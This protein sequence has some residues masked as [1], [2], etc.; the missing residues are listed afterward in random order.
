[1]KNAFLGRLIAFVFLKF[2]I[3]CSVIVIWKTDE[4]TPVLCRATIPLVILSA[5]V[6]RMQPLWFC[7]SLLLYFLYNLYLGHRKRRRKGND[8]SYFA[9]LNPFKSNPESYIVRFTSK[10]TKETVS[11]NIG[12]AVLRFVYC[13]DLSFAIPHNA[14]IIVQTQ[15]T[16]AISKVVVDNAFPYVIKYFP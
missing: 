11:P 2:Y 8:V 3:P 9:Y 7:S 6:K 12:P 13:N 16:L 10:H 5:C 4:A 1:M 15:N 14:A